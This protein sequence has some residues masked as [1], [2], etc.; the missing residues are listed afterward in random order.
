MS[1]VNQ[2]LRDL[3]KQQEGERVV[4]EAPKPSL[5]ERLPRIPMPLLA[6]AGVGLLMLVCWWLAGALS[7]WMFQYETEPVAIQQTLE[8]APVDDEQSAEAAP[9]SGAL[10]PEEYPIEAGE[11]IAG[12]QVSVSEFVE[13]EPKDQA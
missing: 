11:P 7:S 9:D 13:E 12:E 6:G 5:L 1:L 4:V 2:M 3:Q 8:A 10:S